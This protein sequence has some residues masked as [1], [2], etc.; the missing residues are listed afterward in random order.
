MLS[1]LVWILAVLP[2][3]IW[4]Y[5]VFARGKFWQLKSFDDD[6]NSPGIL[7]GWPSVVAIIPARNEARTIGP[8]I[9]SLAGQDYPGKLS[10]IVVDDHSS[11]DTADRAI[12]AAKSA[13]SSDRV[14]V[15]SAAEL[16]TGWTGKVWALNEGVRTAKEVLA[17]ASLPEF[18]WFTDADIVHAPDTLRRLVFRAQN[19]TL[20]LASLMVL[21]QVKTF[22]ER[23]LIPPFLYFFLM[24][25]PPQ[26]IADPRNRTAGAAGGCVLLRRSALEAIG[27]L[28]SIQSEVIDDCALARAVKNTG[29]R[30]CM[31]LTRSSV[32]L[33]PYGTL[34]EIRDV[35][36][37]TAFTQL[38]YS[39]LLLVGTLAG[40]LITYISPIALLFTHSPFIRL[41]GF[42]TWLLMMISFLPTVRFYRL[43]PLWALLLPL[44][45]L[46]YS[47]ATWLSAAR[48]WMGHGGQWKGRAQAPKAI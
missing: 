2:L 31:R 34:E 46:F 12:E 29:A 42:T 27:G 32:S 15:H 41:L 35:I 18:F 23:L 8:M 13:G 43:S 5:L 6:L 7:F 22:P 36:A 25:Y 38:L 47:Y 37:R 40:M 10:V 20:G 14:A 4:I 39:S 24:L 21:L 9:A 17:Q 48:Y 26:W 45:A 33:R 11:D 44:A 3:A 1:Q 30:I 28:A 19:E 16:P